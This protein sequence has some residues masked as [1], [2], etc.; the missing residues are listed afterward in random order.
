MI[1]S[2]I[3][4][5][6]YVVVLDPLLRNTVNI[7][8][9]LKSGGTIIINSAAPPEEIE[10]MSQYKVATVDA[11][12]IAL[13]TI[14]RPITNTTMMGALVKATGLVDL[15]SVEK[16][17]EHRFPAIAEKNIKALRRAYE[18]TEI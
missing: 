1:R 6:D 16:Q 11:T 15:S 2:L 7:T 3:H 5:P 8:E 17:I 14:G 10:F 13:E 12:K 18:E 4:E 9:G